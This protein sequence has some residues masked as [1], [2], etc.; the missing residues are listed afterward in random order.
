MTRDVRIVITAHV[1]RLRRTG[2]KNR[3]DRAADR[4]KKATVAHMAQLIGGWNGMG[5][6]VN[7]ESCSA[8][9]WG[10]KPL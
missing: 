5:T 2:A 1:Q 10:S 4:E 9:G 7:A 6:G 8:R 3:I